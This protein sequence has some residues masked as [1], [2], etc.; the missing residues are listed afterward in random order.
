VPD[1][2]Y[3]IQTERLVLRPLT[4]DDIDAV[5]AYQS[6]EEVCRYVPFEPRSRE[7][8]A[9]RI[10]NLLLS[11]MTDEG[12]AMTIGAELRETGQLLGDI[13]L[14]WRSKEHGS[15]EI[16][17]A[18]HPNYQG[19]GY[20][21]EAASATLAL[22][23]EVFDLH[24]VV[25]RIDARN[26]AS[27]SLARRIGMRQEAYLRENEWFKGEWTDEIDYAILAA[28]WRAARP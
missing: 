20:A 12:Q 9:D 14:A 26:D 6:N 11:Q 22:A 28:E 5:H 1:I 24:R 16:G 21:T 19:H 4:L 23:F 13:M 8:V 2:S 27:L 10:E 3:P 15:G 25:A 18:F 17:W 7:V